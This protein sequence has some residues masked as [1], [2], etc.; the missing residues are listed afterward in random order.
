MKEPQ[1]GAENSKT[2]ADALDQLRVVLVRTQHPGNIGAT[3]RAMKTM[4]LSDLVLAA[5]QRPRDERSVAMA[6]GAT[7]VLEG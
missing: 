6:S 4:G 2:A 3:A 1:K 7:D 5:P